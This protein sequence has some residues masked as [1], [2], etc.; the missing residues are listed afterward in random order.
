MKLPNSLKRKKATIVGTVNKRRGE[1]PNAIKTMK[2]LPL[3]STRIFKNEGLTLTVYHGKP[4]K[5]VLVLSS[6]HKAVSM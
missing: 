3:F 4:S 2:L 1:V 5:N 6:V